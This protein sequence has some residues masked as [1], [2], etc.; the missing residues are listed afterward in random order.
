[1]RAE[2][3]EFRNLRSSN[4]IGVADG[5]HF[6]GVMLRDDRVE[7]GEEIVEEGDYLQRRGDGGD[8]REAANV[9]EE[10]GGVL[11]ELR[12]HRLPHFEVFGHRARL[13]YKYA[14]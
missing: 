10:N 8:S 5:L 14:G 3:K 13:A 1:M 4:H 12:H 11:I 9:G 2:H 7:A 6:V